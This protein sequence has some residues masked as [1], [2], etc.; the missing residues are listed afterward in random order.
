MCA[1]CHTP[2]NYPQSLAVVSGNVKFLD[3]RLV[4][5]MSISEMMQLNSS[6]EW[7]VL[8]YVPGS[9]QKLQTKDE[10]LAG[11]SLF[12]RDKF[13]GLYLHICFSFLF[14][15]RCQQVRLLHLQ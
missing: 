9:H 10:F 7:V 14:S 12:S 2:Q 1:I 8:L 4:L 6:V 15:C 3:L 5:K 13:C 11:W